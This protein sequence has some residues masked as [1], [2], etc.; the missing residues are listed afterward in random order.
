MSKTV[1]KG[2][3]GQIRVMYEA[4]RKGYTI[5]V[6]TTSN[7]KYDLIIERKGRLERVQVKSTESDGKT[8]T[9]RCQSKNKWSKHRYTSAD[10][11][12]IICYDS[13][14]DQTYYIPSSMLGEGM[15]TITLR[16]IPGQNSQ[17]CMIHWAKNFMAW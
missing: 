4:T 11:D 1:I 7:S 12:C 14:T 9:V 16:I 8:I 10:V 6:P 5:S 17:K 2:D 3:L 15:T 13:T